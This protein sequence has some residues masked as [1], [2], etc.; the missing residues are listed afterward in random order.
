VVQIGTGRARQTRSN[1]VVTGAAAAVNVA[2]NLALI[3]AYGRMGATIAT[4][5][6]YTLLFVGM[7]WRAQRVFPVSYQWRRVATLGLA[8]VGLTV[9]GKLLDVPLPVALALTA[10][11]PLVL[12]VLGFYLPAERQRLRR[13]LPILGR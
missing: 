8:A 4:V 13:L 3:P 5:V 2:L 7:A 12:L 1:W 9:L 6:A 10:A 11:F